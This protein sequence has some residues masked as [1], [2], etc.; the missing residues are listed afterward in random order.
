MQCGSCK[1]YYK[2]DERTGEC[3]RHPPTIQSLQAQMLGWEEDDMNTGVFPK[4]WD[5]TY[6][7]EWLEKQTFTFSKAEG[8]MSRSE[9]VHCD[10]CHKLIGEDKFQINLGQTRIWHD[11]GF[12]QIHCCADF[13][14]YDCMVNFIKDEVARG[15]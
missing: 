11:G 7:G 1:W 9:I 4:V 13:C 6:C 5:H 14:S 2:Y 10:W 12:T 8:E 15:H 3:R